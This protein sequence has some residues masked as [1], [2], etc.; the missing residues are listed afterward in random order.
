MELNYNIR[1]NYYIN[2]INMELNQ[3]QL[4]NRLY[5]KLKN[6]LFNNNY[7]PT[8]LYFLEQYIHTLKITN[9]FLQNFNS[10][11]TNCK[12]QA[13]LREYITTIQDVEIMDKII[14]FLD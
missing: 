5:F 4:Q 14:K 9:D 7:D 13:H 2:N 3:L 8:D 12:Y 1:I 10:I 6:I 11:M